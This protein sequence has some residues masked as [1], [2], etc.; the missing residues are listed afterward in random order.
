MRQRR[1]VVA[2][3][4]EPGG[5]GVAGIVIIGIGGDGVFQF[6]LCRAARC[7]AYKFEAR[8]Q[9]LGL[10]IGASSDRQSLQNFFA[11]VVALGLEQQLRQLQFRSIAVRIGFHGTGQER[12]RL[13]HIALGLCRKGLGDEH[14]RGAGNMPG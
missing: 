5:Q 6:L 13:G 4:H 10:W 3:D 7:Q 14:I 8:E 11:F 2:R 12:Q 9:C 1:L